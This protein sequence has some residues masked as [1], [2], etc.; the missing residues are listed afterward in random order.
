M[1]TLNVLGIIYFSIK[2]IL[3]FVDCLAEHFY[4][5]GAQEDFKFDTHPWR[6][7]DSIFWLIFMISLLIIF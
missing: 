2:I 3:Y 7:F 4:P 5:L 6:L 1:E